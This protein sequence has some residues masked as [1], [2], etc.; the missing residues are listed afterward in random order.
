[1]NTSPS[2]RF[3]KACRREPV[4]HT[5][6]WLMRQAGRYMKEYRD[7]REKYSILEL[8]KNP[9]LAADVTM[10]PMRAFHPDAAIIFADILTILEP[11]GFQLDFIEG[12]GP[13]IGNPLREAADLSRI[14]PADAEAS[15]SFTLD[16]IRLVRRDLDEQTALIGFAGSPFTLACYAVEGGS[17]R[18]FLRIKKFMHGHHDAFHAFMRL[19]TD[20]TAHY[21]RGQLRA[22][23]DAVQIFDSWAGILSPSDYRTFVLP[24][25]RELAQAV[26]GNAPV[27]YFATDSAGLLRDFAQVG[28]DVIGVDWRIALDDAW[29]IIGHDTGIQGNLDPALLFSAP[30]V[31]RRQADDV[32]RRAGRRP[33]HIFN[34]GHGVLPQTP[35]EHVSALIDYVQTRS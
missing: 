7:L 15:L 2:C 26:K 5:P 22:G 21:L 1:M 10:Q 30:D 31:I 8:I 32:L 24:Y 25:I 17:S 28:A 6:I 34:L 18:N 11:M 3:L 16:A 35:V 14:Q 20:A 19:A 23:A 12:T 29:A 13:V 9:E 27:I 33:G 4:D